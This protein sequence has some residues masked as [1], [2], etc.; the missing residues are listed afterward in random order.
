[1]YTPP[2]DL[3]AVPQDILTL[4]EESIIPSPHSINLEHSPSADFL[5]RSVRRKAHVAELYHENSK[6]CPY[7]TL[8]PTNREALEQIRRWYFRTAY[9]PDEAIMVRQEEAYV[10]VRLDELPRL[11]HPLLTPFM[12]P[13][14]DANLLYGLDLLLLYQ[15]RLLRIIPEADYFWIER[16][17]VPQHRQALTQSLYTRPEIAHLIPD[18]ITLFV[19]G[20]PW[21]YML[22][23]GPRGYRYTLLD[24]GQLLERVQQRA[25]AEEIP[26][27]VTH[28]FHD[29][30]VDR[31]VFA[32]GV[33]RSTLS[34][35]V[36]DATS[37]S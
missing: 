30:A 33:E 24:A 5:Y 21:R 35:M 22:L 15:D 19:L 18:G 2:V 16:T 4:L 27:H 37:S 26:L 20:C 25:Q 12:E 34:M 8:Q 1:M 17:L 11:V 31:F 28:D 13:G 29:A 3:S 32:D 9:A 23:F 14:N 6:L 7:A 10:R 36:M